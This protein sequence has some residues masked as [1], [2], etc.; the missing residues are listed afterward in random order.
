MKVKATGR[1]VNLK[2]TFI[3]MVTKRLQKFD[4]FFEDEAEATVSV[5]VEKNRQTVEVT[6]RSRGF[7]YRAERTAPD[8]E[9]A[10]ADAVD[11]LTRQ[12]VKNKEK[13]GNRVKT[14]EV[15]MVGAELQYEPEEE[16]GD[17]RIEREKR[18]L[19]EPM[20]EQEAI[21]QM[22]LLGHTFFLFKNSETNEINVVYRR[23]DGAYGLLIPI[24]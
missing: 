18:F 20:S 13:L 1:K 7:L 6:V 21:L 12:I 8:M 17:Y 10:F 19:V 24:E 15:E 14:R 23:N 11:L 4:R 9:T 2:Q 22:E 5:T 16:S 3:D